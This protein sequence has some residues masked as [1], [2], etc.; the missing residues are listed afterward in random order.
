MRPARAYVALKIEAV[1]GEHTWD[2]GALGERQA[3]FKH[4]DRLRDVPLAA[5]EHTNKHQRRGKRVGLCNHFGQPYRLFS[6]ATPLGKV[7]QF[8][9]T[10]GGSTTRGH[11][12][13]GDLA[14]VR[15]A[16][17]AGEQ[18]PHPLEEVERL[19]KGPHVIVCDAQGSLGDDLVVERPTGRG[20]SERPLACRDGTVM[21]AHVGEVDAQITSDPSV[22]LVITQPFGKDFGFAQ[23][24]ENPRLFAERQ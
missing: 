17:L 12:G 8:G 7:P 21:L 1:R 24:V 15:I 19:P 4:E 9:Q 10:R 16:L 18:R 11:S 2:V 6:Q 23:V 13:R 3:P 20:Q 14:K 5:V 22:S